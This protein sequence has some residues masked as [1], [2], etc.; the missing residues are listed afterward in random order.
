MTNPFALQS[1]IAFPRWLLLLVTPLH[2]LRTPPSRHTAVLLIPSL[3]IRFHLSPATCAVRVTSNI[4][5]TFQQPMVVCCWGA[6]MGP[7]FPLVLAQERHCSPSRNT[8]RLCCIHC[9]CFRFGGGAGLL[10][11]RPTPNL[12]DQG[13][14]LCQVSTL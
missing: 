9:Q 3:F 5:L 14:T 12:E 10:P 6:T 13:V 11:L 2:L 7:I 8:P 4:V 1:H